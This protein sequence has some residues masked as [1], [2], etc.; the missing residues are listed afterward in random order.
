[1]LNFYIAGPWFDDY[2]KAQIDYTKEQYM[3]AKSVTKDLYCYFPDEHNAA[4]PQEVFKS[5]LVAIKEAD[6]VLAHISRKDVGT[7][8]EIGYAKAKR[9]PVILVGETEETFK[10]KTNI[11]LAHCTTFCITRDKIYKALT[12]CLDA[13]DIIKI[14]NTWE[15]K[16]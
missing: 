16:E 2:A 9:I 3:K 1:M 5:N 11:M 12:E 4:S 13:V 10:S 15:N 7:A 8:F 14:P 6:F